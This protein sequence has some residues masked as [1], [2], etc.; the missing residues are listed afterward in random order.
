MDAHKEEIRLREPYPTL[1]PGEV[2]GENEE[3]GESENRRR[4]RRELTDRARTNQHKRERRRETH[5]EKR[6]RLIEGGDSTR[7]V[8]DRP[9]QRPGGG[10]WVLTTPHEDTEAR[11]LIGGPDGRGGQR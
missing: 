2:E 4:D 7:K 6:M 11:R 1:Y 9:E 3:G 5:Y 8:S 10:E